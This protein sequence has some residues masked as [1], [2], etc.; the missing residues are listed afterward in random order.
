VALLNSPDMLPEAM[1]FLVRALLAVGGGPVPRQELLNLVS[2]PGLG[3]AM[4]QLGGAYVHE[5]PNP[6]EDD[7]PDPIEDED[8]QTAETVPGKKR[9]GG[10]VIASQSLV[11]LKTL[12]LVTVEKQQVSLVS[13]ARELWSK[14][15]EVTSTEF[16]ALL[17][18]N[19]FRLSDPTA[20]PGNWTNVNDLVQA[21]ELVYAADKPLH[22][23]ARFVS[24]NS[25]RGFRE[26]QSS[27]F[28]D[29][30]K[31]WP[32]RNGTRW[33]AFCRWSFYLG[34]TGQAGDSG[35]I[36]DASTALKIRLSSLPKDV[37]DA[38]AFIEQ[39]AD[40]VPL[41]DGGALQRRFVPEASGSTRV[42]SP[43]LSISLL[44]MEADGV[45][46]LTTQSDTDVYVI[47]LHTDQSGDRAFT[48]VEWLADDE[49][50]RSRA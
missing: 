31:L 35:V 47:R 19:V 6:T 42:L 22:P 25:E 48:S 40:A 16:R 9:T 32:V 11:A 5:N 33:T 18:D 50:R 4:E 23:F 3:A 2:P 24:A 14:P 46:Q 26:L 37:Y 7:E 13:T 27:T 21:V 43:A 49:D 8:D 39:C 28:G 44:Q 20:S 45:V 34:L 38:G 36:A 1:R 17:L 29:D 15:A 41:L 30:K 12:G 10:V